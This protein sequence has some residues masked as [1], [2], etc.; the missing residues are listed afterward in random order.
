MLEQLKKNTGITLQVQT[1]PWLR[2]IYEMQNGQVDGAFKASFKTDRLEYSVYPMVN[3][4]LDVDKR[5]TTESYHLY[6]LKGSKISWD[7]KTFTNL[8]GK[9]GVQ[10][11]FSIADFLTSM[12]IPVDSG[13]NSAETNLRM[14]VRGRFNGVALQTQEGDSLLTGEFSEV[15]RVNPALVEKPYFLVFS[16]QFFADH[17]DIANQIW[18]AIAKIRESADYI[19]ASGEAK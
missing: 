12:G 15:E 5:M 1:A 17:P 18:A 4:K 6:R 8:D 11:G 10:T 7:G 3:G 14:L 2:C 13:A 16:R 19:K 9:I